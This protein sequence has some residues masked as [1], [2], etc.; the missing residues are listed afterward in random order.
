[1]S[2]PVKSVAV[3]GRDAAAWLAAAALRRAFGPSSPIVKVVELPSV[4]APVDVLPSLP[5][6]ASIHR[7]L[8][9]DE[10]LVFATCDAVPMVAQRFSNWGKSAPPFF[11]AYDDEPPPGAN[12]TFLQSWVK[13]AREGLRVPL[14]DF[15]LGAACARLGRAPIPMVGGSGISASYGYHLD[16]SSYPQL[17]REYAL[18]SGAEIAG[19]GVREVVVEGD[20]IRSLQTADGR[21]IEADL[22]VDASGAERIL[23]G[24]MPGA[25]F[26]SWRQWFPCD[27]MIACSGPRLQ[28]LPAFS[29]V[30]A[31]QKGWAGLFPLQNRTG[32]VSLFSSEHAADQEVAQ[33]LAILTRMPIVGEAVVSDVNSGAE[34]QPWI[35][36]CVAIGNSALSV[37]PL[38]GLPIHV[39]QGCISYLVTLFPTD[40]ALMSEAAAY[41]RSM[42]LFG[43]NIRDFQLAHYKLNRRFDDPLWD[44]ARDASVPDSLQR[45]IDAFAARGMVVIHDEE[46]FDEQSWALL[47]VGSGLMPESYD[48]RIELVPDAEHIAKVQD[49]LRTVSELAQRMPAVEQILSAAQQLRAEVKG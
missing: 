45:R 14:A 30:S 13:G 22:F 8:G 34:R 21:T 6:L 3:V 20:R 36:N 27:R 40:N 15:S 2:E 48:P 5:S 42:Q 49:R 24:R 9:L 23:I 25:E 37:E 1:M 26:H 19:S 16:A 7:L 10:R 43:E 38:H 28:N 17:L 31:F 32:I 11:V 12:A 46:F 44:R 35:G 33:E 4:L 41:N 47:F 39:A 29:Q 18:R